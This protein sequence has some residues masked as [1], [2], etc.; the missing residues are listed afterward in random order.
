MNH[1]VTMQWLEGNALLRTLSIT[2]S[3]GELDEAL[4]EDELAVDGMA[5]TEQRA[6]LLVIEHKLEALIAASFLTFEVRLLPTV[7]V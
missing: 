1:E 3:C 6:Q 5:V 2:C 7:K 4:P